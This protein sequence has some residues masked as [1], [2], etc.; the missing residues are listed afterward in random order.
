MAKPSTKVGSGFLISDGRTADETY[1]LSLDQLPSN[2]KVRKGR[3]VVRDRKISANPF[4]AE[5][6]LKKPQRLGSTKIN[7][8]SLEA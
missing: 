5:G 2:F 7:M 1:H 6:D 8:N 4:T 3:L